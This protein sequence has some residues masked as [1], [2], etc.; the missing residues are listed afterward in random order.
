MIFIWLPSAQYGRGTPRTPSP[1]AAVCGIASNP[2]AGS[3]FRK[4]REQCPFDHIRRLYARSIDW[5]KSGRTR[6]NP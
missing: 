6:Q 5:A 1:V 4:G 3:S 2:R